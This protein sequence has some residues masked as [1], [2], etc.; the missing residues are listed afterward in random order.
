MTTKRSRGRP[1]PPPPDGVRQVV[2]SGNG[3]TVEDAE[4]KCFVRWR[5]LKFLRTKR[6]AIATYQ[7]MGFEEVAW[8]HNRRGTVIKVTMQKPIPEMSLETRK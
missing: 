5:D 6:V 1:T 4:G 8:E 3:I 2:I 7:A